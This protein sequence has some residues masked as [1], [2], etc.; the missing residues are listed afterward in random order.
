MLTSAI[1]DYLPTW[2]YRPPANGPTGNIE[3]LTAKGD[4]KTIE[5]KSN[6]Q[7]YDIDIKSPGSL[8]IQTYYFPGWKVWVDGKLVETKPLSDPLQIGRMLIDISSGAH[9]VELK[10]TNTPIRSVGN[11]ISMISW[12]LLGIVLLKKVIKI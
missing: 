3:F 4:Y 10:F 9:Q 12:G 6:F 7:K 1:F 11:I 8:I 2:A 5:K